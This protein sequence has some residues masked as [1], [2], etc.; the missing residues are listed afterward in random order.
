MAIFESSNTNCVLPLLLYLGPGIRILNWKILVTL[1]VVIECSF[2]SWTYPQFNCERYH[3]EISS[4]IS[5]NSNS[6]KLETFV[7][8][9]SKLITVRW[10]LTDNAFRPF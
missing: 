4:N 7:H 1:T 3:S 10:P 2:V 6:V 9:Y 5:K 8:F